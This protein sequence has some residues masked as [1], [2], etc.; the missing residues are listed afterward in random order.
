MF[1]VP[2]MS[3]LKKYTNNIEVIT[4]GKSHS[5]HKEDCAYCNRIKEGPTGIITLLKVLNLPNTYVTK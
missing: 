3:D 5:C 1:V 4:T 2:L